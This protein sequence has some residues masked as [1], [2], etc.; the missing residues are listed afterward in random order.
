[1]K[2]HVSLLS[3]YK[4]DTIPRPILEGPPPEEIEGEGEYK[5][6]EILN[7]Q[8]WRRRLEYLVK[9]VGYGEGHNSNWEPVQNLENMQNKIQGFHHKYPDAVSPD[10]RKTLPHRQNK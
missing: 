7:S 4:V 3:K 5:V 9:W 10:N 2:I 6:E 8:Y 1:M